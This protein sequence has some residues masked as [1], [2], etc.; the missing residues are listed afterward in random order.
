MVHPVN[1]VLLVGGIFRLALAT[2]RTSAPAGA[3]VVRSGTSTAGEFATISA[4][5]SSLPNDKTTQSIFIFPGTY[6]EQVDITRTGP[7]T[8]NYTTF[9]AETIDLIS[10]DRFT[11]TQMTP[12][13]TRTTR[14]RCRQEYQLAQRDPMMPAGH[15]ASTRTT[16]AC[17]M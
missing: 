10:Y 2:S 1:F 6:T 4:A 16:S 11:A 15:C 14:L 5:V 7:L 9:A 17:T 3:V 13:H 8:V 12:V